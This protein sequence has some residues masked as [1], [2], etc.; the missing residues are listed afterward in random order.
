MDAI[1]HLAAIPTPHV[2]TPE[3]AFNINVAGT[4]NVY[5]AAARNGISRVVSASSINA[6]GFNYGRKPFQIAYLPVDEQTPGIATDVYSFSKQINEDTARYYY[7]RD[8]IS[9]ACIRIPWVYA[10]TD[11]NLT[12]LRERIP[13]MR[14]A[15]DELVGL[16]KQER[17]Q[18]VTEIIAVFDAFRTA[19]YD[20][21]CQWPPKEERLR[22]G[23]PLLWGRS[24]FWAIIDERD[25]AQAFAKATV[26]DYDGIHV[27]FVNDSHNFTGIETT[28]LAELM[29]PAPETW[30]GVWK[31]PVAGTDCL[32]SI[33]KARELIGFE[34]EYSME[35]F[36]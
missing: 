20:P 29:F 30:T 10:P 2:T 24:D 32:V 31:R 13:L 22:Q 26:T 28:A 18:K 34:P 1:L 33:D 35:R 27:L 11:E 36:F 15:F 9:G 23:P 25:S 6:L 8:G 14:E 12:Q 7:R 17:S 19:Q 5:E 21:N 3:V 16:P 4:F